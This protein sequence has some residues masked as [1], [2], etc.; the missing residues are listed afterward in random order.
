MRRISIVLEPE[1]P[2]SL[3]P[4]RDSGDLSTKFVAAKL[5]SLPGPPLLRQ[6]RQPAKKVDRAELKQ[7]LEN[8]VRPCSL[9]RFERKQRR[10][11]QEAAAAAAQRAECWKESFMQKMEALDQSKASKFLEVVS[12]ELRQRRWQIRDIFRDVDRAKSGAISECCL[13][14]PS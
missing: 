9:L 11:R 3:S 13:S 5:V 8:L 10:E 2:L 1:H 7:A 4:H 12:E 6:I 14:L